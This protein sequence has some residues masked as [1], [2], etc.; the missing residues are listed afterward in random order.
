MD[1]QQ[2]GACAYG[3][4]A[5]ASASFE[6]P[7]IVPATAEAAIKTS[8]PPLA[9]CRYGNHILVWRVTPGPLPATSQIWFLIS[10]DD[11]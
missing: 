10:G 2:R 9:F 1:A 11:A 4:A 5:G 6:A 3:V 8:I 7:V